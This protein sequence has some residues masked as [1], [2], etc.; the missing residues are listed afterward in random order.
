MKV[1]FSTIQDADS[2]LDLEAGADDWFDADPPTPLAGSVLSPVPA[3]NTLIG[4][5]TDF[6]T[7]LS[8]GAYVEADY[9][10]SRVA[11]IASATGLT[12]DDS[13][14][15]EEAAEIYLHSPDEWESRKALAKKKI[16][17]LTS[18]YR[19]ITEQCDLSDFEV[20]DGVPQV[21]EAIMQASYLLALSILRQP[22][23]SK[24]QINAANGV[25]REKIGDMEVE[26]T[27]GQAAEFDA[28]VRRLLGS[29]YS[30]NKPLRMNRRPMDLGNPTEIVELQTD[31]LNV[32]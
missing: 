8:V 27:G 30:T 31:P 29:Y 23:E 20:V 1:G 5:G 14:S 7:D 25:K 12:L 3:D 18:A 6:T 13:I 9:Q 17:A 24:H 4:T 21:T 28:R 15:V 11:S 10:F 2:F 26:Y 16:R 22:S 32:L 19:R